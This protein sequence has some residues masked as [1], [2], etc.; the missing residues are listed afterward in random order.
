MFSMTVRSPKISGVWKTREMPIWLISCGLRPS[1]DW[2]SKLT[3]PVSGISLP[4]RQLRSVDL[5]AP[6]GPMIA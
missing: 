1:T 4:T 5:P 2:P 3:E 6:F